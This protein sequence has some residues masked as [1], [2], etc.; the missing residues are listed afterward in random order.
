MKFR[1]QIT[2][3]ILGSSLLFLAQ[4]A[5]R[6]MRLEDLPTPEPQSL[7]SAVNANRTKLQDLQGALTIVLRTPDGASAIGVNLSYLQPD[8][9]KLQFKGAFGIPLGEL[10]MARGI[11]KITSPLGDE[12][13]QGD[14]QSLNLPF[15]FGIS[16]EPA[17]LLSLLLPIGPPFEHEESPKMTIDHQSQTYLVSWADSSLN[18]QAWF[19]PFEPVVLRELISST[20]TDTVIYKEATNVD[21]IS[22]IYLPYSWKTQIG[23]GKEAYIAQVK[24]SHCKVNSGLTPSAFEIEDI[25][26]PAS[27]GAKHEQ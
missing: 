23:Y 20:G 27:P 19:D 25:N 8:L 18:H 13:A 22:G 5:K 26:P 1:R 3:F 9:Y 11:Y 21:S 12:D 17:I 15:G 2:Y 7:I 16:F 24:L 10:L 14:L 4:C 6:G